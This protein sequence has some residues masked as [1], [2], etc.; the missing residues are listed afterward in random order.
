MRVAFCKFWNL[1]S[2][3]DFLQKIEKQIKVDKF[4]KQKLHMEIDMKKTT[5]KVL[6]KKLYQIYKHSLKI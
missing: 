3:F 6:R 2:D 4:D 5:G 1:D